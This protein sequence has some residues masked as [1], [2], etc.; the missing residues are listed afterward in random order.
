MPIRLSSPSKMPCYSW[1]IPAFDTCPG[2]VIDFSS[3]DGQL[4]NWPSFKRKMKKANQVPACSG[5][6]AQYG[7]YTFP[8]S[9]NLR[10]HN[11]KDWKRKNWVKDMVKAIKHESYFR[12][13]DSGDMYC[14]ELALKIEEIVK[15]CP[16]TKFW[17]PTRSHKI[18]LIAN[19][20][21]RLNR[22]ANCVVRISSDS[23]VGGI[24]D[25]ETNSTIVPIGSVKSSKGFLVCQ[26]FNNNGKCGDCRA[27]WNKNLK[28]VA[29]PAHGNVM[30]S[31]L[32]KLEV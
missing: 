16:N 8:G 21:N 19:V 17:I 12:F 15:A 27:C 3:Y 28:T 6:Y 26:S 18:K 7:N 11:L 30:K 2:A 1:S 31:K 4:K 5:C 13:F 14:V 29:Y 9:V 25:W 32:K 22:L 10:K 23:I 24:V 20:I